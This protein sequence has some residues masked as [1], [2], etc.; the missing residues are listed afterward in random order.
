MTFHPC[1]IIP[2]YNHGASIGQVLD[3]L[4]PLGLT[5]FV[6]DDGSDTDTRLTLEKLAATQIN[7]QLFRLPVNSGKG[8]AVLYGFRQA[9][10]LGYSHALQVDA[11]G[12]HMLEDAPR[13]LAL[14]AANPG[15]VISGK[16]IFDDSV[17]KSRLYGRYLTH[18]WV[19]VETLSL[20]IGDSM[21]GFR[22]YPLAA[23]L[24]LIDH[25]VVPTRMDFDIDIIVRL[26]WRGLTII[27]LPT[28]VIYPA[29]G[30]SHFDTLRDNIRISK[31]HARLF[32]GMLPRAP[33]LLWRQLRRRV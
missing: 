19:W 5:I 30:V 17:P 4:A 33:G 2:C 12:Q 23:T 32:F 15:A 18:F 24:D 3:R 9:H 1:V 7:L 21:C 31:M 16:P 14:S 10:A 25:A 20:A 29:D 11:D 22:C 6:V 8:A 13:F 28:K 26:Y 27:N